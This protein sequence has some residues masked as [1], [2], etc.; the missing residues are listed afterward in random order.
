MTKMKIEI[1]PDIWKWMQPHY[2]KWKAE[3]GDLEEE[4]EEELEGIGEGSS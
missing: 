2:E 4:Q 3:E 1:H